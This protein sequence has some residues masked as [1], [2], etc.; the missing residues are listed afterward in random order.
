MVA[1]VQP[2]RRGHPDGHIAEFY[3]RIAAKHGNAKAMVATGAKLL[4]VVYCVLT[5]MRE[6]TREAP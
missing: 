6:Y 3:D 2:H 5:E 4:R 1:S